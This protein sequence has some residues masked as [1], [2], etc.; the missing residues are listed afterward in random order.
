MRS[1]SR[2]RVSHMNTCAEHKKRAQE[3]RDKA[4]RQI[5]D[6]DLEDTEGDSS[7]RPQKSPR[8]SQ[9]CVRE[10]CSWIQ[11]GLNG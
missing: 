1:V 3:R 8:I 2:A 10:C 5:S 11:I 7:Q 4:K 9:V 6:T